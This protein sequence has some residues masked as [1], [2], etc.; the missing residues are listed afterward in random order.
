MSTFQELYLDNFKQV[1][2]FLGGK[3]CVN[4]LD[5]ENSHQIKL[6]SPD[7]RNF[8]IRVRLDNGRICITGSVIHSRGSR[9][10]LACTVSPDRPARQIARDIQRKIL[11]AAPPLIAEAL[12]WETEHQ[13]DVE[14]ARYT[15]ALIGK[16][17]H[18]SS[19]YAG[20]CCWKSGDIYGDVSH[21]YKDMYS[22]KIAQLSTENLIK[23]IGFISTLS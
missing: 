10:G 14:L 13:Q 16:L 6:T 21:G 1:C 2:L 9:K 18:V 17:A 4:S 8:A 23:V 7:F 3:W 11:S 19:N 15:K 5:K 12:K 22:M 20:L